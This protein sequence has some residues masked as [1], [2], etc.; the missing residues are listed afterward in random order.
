MQAN[1]FP[2]AY[3]I[4]M[5][6]VHHIMVKK[7][8]EKVRETREEE[9]RKIRKIDIV[10]SYFCKKILNFVFIASEVNITRQQIN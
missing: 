1:E 4:F 8:R 2:H 6:I 3:G 10:E 9:K 5:E 7:I